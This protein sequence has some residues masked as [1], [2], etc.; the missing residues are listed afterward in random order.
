MS[1]KEAA[2]AL[3]P[4][5]FPEA[6]V[7][8]LQEVGVQVPDGSAGRLYEHF[9]LVEDWNTR[10]NLTGIVSPVEAAI[11]HY[12]DSLSCLRA[13]TPAQG[14]SL[15]D[16][17][18]GAGFPGI[19]LKLVR[20]D[21]AL[22]LIESNGKKAGFLREACR[23]LRL[24]GA[25]VAQ[26]RAEEAGRDTR[27]RERFD[28]GVARAVSELRV[29]AE[30]VLPLV[31]VGGA[32]LAQKGPDLDQ[33]TVAAANAIARLGGE[34]QSVVRFELPYGMG[35][36]CVVVIRKTKATDAKYPRRTGVPA[37]KPL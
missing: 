36:R 9:L 10:I 13:F 3:M 30:Y 33:E 19:P 7:K 27:L 32:F 22:T 35:Q 37:K 25:N 8:G 12:V 26:T 31:K 23:E 11:K 14:A 21:I 29:L 24:E 2:V 15:V 4:G 1:V 6:V 20:P 18:S 5:D 17:G 16:V 34:V 28:V